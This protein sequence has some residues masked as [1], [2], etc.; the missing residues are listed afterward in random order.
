[1]FVL[2]GKDMK[3]E[4]MTLEEWDTVSEL[5]RGSI[6][7][8]IADEVIFNMI[9]DIAK[10]TL[11]KLEYM[12]VGRLVENGIYLC[13]EDKAI[14]VLR[15]LHSSYKHFKFEEVVK[16]I[17]FRHRINDGE[18][19]QGEGLVAKVVERDRSSKHEGKKGNMSMSKFKAKDGCFERGS[20]EH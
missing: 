13:M 20:K 14:F 5:G 7:N 6:E 12:Y 18:S 11:K 10:Q 16:D 1:M 4:T 17:L 8:Y 2:A 9:E 19:S 15:S 3:L